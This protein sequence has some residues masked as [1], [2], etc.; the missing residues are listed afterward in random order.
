MRV[1]LDSFF[2]DLRYGLRM[3]TR[4][5]GLTLAAV[6]SLAVG[7]G[8]NTIAFSLADELL[9]KT[10]PVRNPDELVLFRWAVK[11]PGVITDTQGTTFED[12][13]ARQG[14]VFSDTAYQTFV[15]EN[16]TLSDLFA[17]APIP[18]PISV[19]VDGQPQAA[20]GEFLSG[21]YYSGLG[22]DAF[23]GRTLTVEDDRPGAEPAAVI[24]HN[25][26]RRRFGLDPGVIG[27]NVRINGVS[28]Q[29]S[30]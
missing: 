16:Q 17:F 3:L 25:Y 2:Q 26:W 8:T 11:G 14:A 19:V 29:L 10:L 21:G 20:S 15:R 22:I 30:E 4:S 9:Y 24:S 23:R 5:K 7:I 27:K 28:S 1:T 6:L 18:G 13:G 12:G